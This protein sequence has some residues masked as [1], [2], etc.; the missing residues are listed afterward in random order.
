LKLADPRRHV[1]SLGGDQLLQLW[2]ERTAIRS[3]GLFDKRADLA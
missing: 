2:S 3:E 1:A